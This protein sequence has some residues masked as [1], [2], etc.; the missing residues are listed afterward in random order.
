MR[1]TTYTY[2]A[3][4]RLTQAAYG[5]GT[6]STYVY[7]QGANGVGRLTSMTDPGP[8]TT[9]WTY[10]AMG[11][12]ATKVQ[13]IGTGTAAR[14]HQLS[15][16]YNPTTGSAHLDDVSDRARSSATPTAPPAKTWSAS[17]LTVPMPPAPSP[18]TRSAASSA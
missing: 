13:T 14:T 4:H 3:L 10:T 1:T 5:D 18:I 15:Y 16:S 2:D 9:S 12:V 8:V 6:L 17:P 11:R 7:D